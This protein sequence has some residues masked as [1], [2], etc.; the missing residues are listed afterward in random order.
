[1]DILEGKSFPDDLLP[2]DPVGDKVEKDQ[3][4]DAD[5]DDMADLIATAGRLFSYSL[6]PEFV[7]D[8]IFNLQVNRRHCHL[9]LVIFSSE[10]AVDYLV[11]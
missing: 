10:V 2:K 11:T 1:M 7:G 5:S 3:L 4:T 9:S 8:G 6:P